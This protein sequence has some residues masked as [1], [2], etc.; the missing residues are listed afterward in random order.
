VLAGTS[1]WFEGIEHSADAMKELLTPVFS[2]PF[3]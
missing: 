2:G 3:R 1:P